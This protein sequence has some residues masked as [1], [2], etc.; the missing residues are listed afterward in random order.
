MRVVAGKYRGKNLISPPDDRVRP[1]TTRIKETLFNV[2]QGH[3]VDARVLDL[4]AGSGALGIECVS[5][6]AAEV[7]FND[8]SRDSV[9]LINQNL[10]GIEGNYRVTCQDFLSSLS[11]AKA[12]GR[13]FDVIFLDP[14]Y[15]TDLAERALQ[16]IF[17][18][19]LLDDDGVIVFEH[20]GEKTYTSQTPPTRRAPSAWELSPRSSSQKSAWGL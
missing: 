11:S 12:A 2:L 16:F 9:A 7:V 3:I 5:R 13:Q 18:E 19:N 14:P 15:A 4:F 20:G 10:K 8:K 1:T 6:G 17:A